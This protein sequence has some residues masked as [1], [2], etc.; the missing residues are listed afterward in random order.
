MKYAFKDKSDAFKAD[1]ILV[2]HA[3]ADHSEGVQRLLDKFHPNQDP[4]P[5]KTKFEFSGPLLINSDSLVRLRQ[6]H[7]KKKEPFASGDTING[8]EV[9]FTFYYP[10]AKGQ[11]Y[12]Y[13]PTVL[14]R[15]LRFLAT[16][17]AV[18][19]PDSSPQNLSSI[20]LNVADPSDNSKV[21]VSLNGDS[22][23]YS[24]LQAL[25][26][27]NPTVFKVPHHGSRYNS[28]P[29][30]TY[31]PDELKE[32]QQ[33][34]AA[35]ALLQ[36]RESPKPHN[37][38]IAHQV[39]DWNKS[40]FQQ[41][42]QSIT[43]ECATAAADGHPTKRQ[44]L[45]V[46]K[47]GL[48]Y[49]DILTELALQFKT[50]LASKG[51][52]V[53]NLLK[54][55]QK[56]MEKIEAN[57]KDPSVCP[58]QVYT[59]GMDNSSL[60]L[61]DNFDYED[62][63]KAVLLNQKAQDDAIWD[64]KIQELGFT[65]PTVNLPYKVSM[66][67]KKLFTYLET[68]RVF[69]DNVSLHL[70][71]NFYIQ[72]K[73]KTFFISSGE[74]FQHPHWQV[75]SGIIQA[76][77]HT[78]KSLP[79]YRCRVLLT[80]G[81]GI[82]ENKL[83]DN[84]IDDW[85]KYVSLQYFG[86]ETA[87]VTIDPD[88]GPMQ[89]L[90]G[91]VEW[92]KD[93]MNK[94]DLLEKYNSTA[95]AMKLKRLRSV[96]EGR[97]YAVKPNKNYWLDFT[98]D[99][100]KKATVFQLS[101]DATFLKLRNTGFS[102]AKIENK[103]EIMFTL[104]LINKLDQVAI[105]SG[106]IGS[107]VPSSGVVSYKLFFTTI[108]NGK[109]TW[110]YLVANGGSVTTSTTF[111]DGSY[112]LFE[113][114][115]A[116]TLR[117]ARSLA[118]SP[119]VFLAQATQAFSLSN[120]LS[121][122]GSTQRELTCNAMLQSLLR[123]PDCADVPQTLLASFFQQV[124]TW[125]VGDSSTFTSISARLVLELPT[126]PVTL[127]SFT[128]ISI[129]LHVVMSQRNVDAVIQVSDDTGVPSKLK[130][131]G[132]C[133]KKDRSGGNLTLARAKTSTQS[134]ASTAPA[135]LMSAD[136]HSQLSL[137]DYLKWIHYSG[138][139]SV[140]SSQTMLNLV[141]SEQVT[142]QLLTSGK[143]SE[144][145]DLYKFI[146]AM[147]SWDVESSSTFEVADNVTL[148]AN[149]SLVLPSKPQK[150]KEF[151]V[152]ST[153]LLIT[154]PK[155]TS[156]TTE[157]QLNATDSDGIPVT[158]T[159]QI[160]MFI[161]QFVQTFQEYLKVLGVKKDPSS[162]NLFDAVMFLLD[163]E[164]AGFL[165]MGSFTRALVTTVL[166]WKVNLEQTT[167]K[168]TSTPVG[169]KLLEATLTALVPDK[170]NTIDLGIGKVFQLTKLAFNV[171][172][173]MESKYIM[174]PYMTADVTVGGKSATITAITPQSGVLPFLKL[175]LT[176]SNT[177]G[178]IV[179]FLNLESS[180]ANLQI[181]MLSE[182]LK[183]IQITAAGFTIQQKVTNSRQS[184]LSSVFFAT[185]F[186]N[187]SSYLPPA[188][189]GLKDI[190]THIVIYQPLLSLRKVALD[191]SFHFEISAEGSDGKP[192]NVDLAAILSAEPVLASTQAESSYNFSISLQ[193]STTYV[194][195][196]EGVSL[197]AMLNTFGLKD[198]MSSAESIPFLKSLLQN[199]VLRNLIVTFNTGS[200]SIQSF[201]LNL[202][203]PGWNL[204]P[205]KLDL[206]SFD[207]YLNYSEGD[208]ATSFKG[209]AVFGGEYSISIQ[210]ELPP[211]VNQLARFSFS[212]SNHDFTIQKFLSVF[213]L[214]SIS[215]VPVVGHVL[216]VAVTDANLSL[217]KNDSGVTATEGQVSLY[218]ESINISSIFRLSQVSATIGFVHVEESNYVFGFSVRGFINE[219]IYLNV[220]YDPNTYVLSGQALVASFQQA[221]LSDVVGTFLQ[222]N[223]LDK[224]S[225]YKHASTSL[226]V[227]ISVA[228]EQKSGDFTLQNLVVDL[229]NVFSIG[230]I[231]LE[232]LKFE[233]RIT[234]TGST[235]VEGRDNLFPAGSTIMLTGVLTSKDKNFGAIVEFN[236]NKDTT[237]S[238]T[239]MAAIR[240]A[241]KNT[242]TL[243]S[244]LSLFDVT[245]PLV[246][247]IEGHEVPDFF[248]LA[249][250]EGLLVLSLPDF[251][252]TSFQVKVET[253]NAVD[254]L[255]S[256]KIT[257][258]NLSFEVK[259]SKSAT[260]T[261]TGTLLGVITLLGIQ[262]AMEG[263]K[264]K[265]GTVFKA[266]VG[267]QTADL[268]EFMKMLTPSDTTTPTIPSNV[269]LPQ[270]IPVGIAELVIGL[271]TNKRCVTFKGTSDL[272]WGID[273]G[274]TDFHIQQLGGRVTGVIS[275]EFHA[276]VIGL[277]QFSSSIQMNS[278]LHFGMKLDTV[279]AVLV[280][281]ASKVKVDSVADNL[282]GFSHPQAPS[283]S[284]SSS[285]SETSNGAV[286]FDSLLPNST[287]S[288]I[289]FS[290][291][292]INL[293]LTQSV[294][295][296]V[297]QIA[298]L[299]TGFLLA[300]KF[301]RDQTRYGYAFGI[302]LPRGFKFSQL[303]KAL[304]P[305]DDI[306]QVR[307]ATCVVMSMDVAKVSD[308]VDRMNAARKSAILP[309]DATGLVFPFTDL[310]IDETTNNLAISNGM[311]VYA[312]FDI[313]AASSD[314]IFHSIV[315]ISS[316]PEIPVVTLSATITKDPTQS[317]FRAHLTQLTLLGKLEFKDT[318]LIYHP[319]S[320]VT[321]ELHGTI[322]VHLGT[323][324]YSFNGMFQSSQ[325]EA[326]FSVTSDPSNQ[327]TILEPLGMFGISLEDARLSLRYNYPKDK[328]HTS[329]MEITASL[330]FYSSNSL[331]PSAE[332]GEKP[333]PI[334]TL[335]GLVIF[336]DYVP[337]VVSVTITPTRPLTIADFIAT[338]F[339]WNYN[340]QYL[341]IGIVNGQIYFAKLPQG[342][343]SITIDGFTY[344]NGYHISADTEVFS[345]EFTIEANIPLDRSGVNITGY[346]KRCIDLG[347]AEFTGKNPSKPGPE[348][349]FATSS[350]S[351]SISIGIG[352]VLF[353]VPLATADI[354]Y[355]LTKKVFTG[356]LT[357]N[358]TI[359]IIK[360]PSISFE[361]SKETGLR[362]TSFPMS[363]AFDF[364]L[365]DKLKNHEDS[366]GNLVDLAFK[367]GIQTKF[368]INTR[369]SKTTEPEVFLADIQ[370]TG[371]YDVLLAGQAKIAS[372][373]LP[374]L[375]VGIPREDDF[376]LH[377]LP[378]FILDLFTENTDRIVKQI[379]ENPQRLA[380]ILGFAVLK[381]VTKK[382]IQTLVCRKVD[383]EDFNPEDGGNDPTDDDFN[384]ADE[385]ENEF[386]DFVKSAESLLEDGLLAGAAAAAAGAEGAGASALGI[387][388][389]IISAIGAILSFFGII[390]SYSKK[391]KKAKE[392]EERI[393]N[394]QKQ[395]RDKIQA[396]L[397]IKEQPQVTFT[398]PDKL[399][400]S[401]NPL[402]D[403][404]A[405]YHLKVTGNFL[406]PPGGQTS[407]PIAVYD[408]T[409]SETL[410]LIKN[411]LFYNVV[412]I[413]VTVN[414]TLT[415][416]EGGYTSTFNG[417][418]YTVEVANVHPTLHAPAQVTAIYT[419]KTLEIMTAASSVENAKA[420]HFE[421]VEGTNKP[422]VLI[423]Q[424]TYTPSQESTT[425]QCVF[426]H[427][428]IPQTSKGPF[429]VRC[430]VVGENGSGIAASAFTYS[431]ALSLVS[432]PKELILTLS[433]FEEPKQ[434]I[435]LNWKLPAST[436]SITGF[437][438]RVV[439]KES[440]TILGSY[441]AK[442]PTSEKDQPPP[443]FPTSYSFAIESVVQGLIDHQLIPT[444]PAA[445]VMEAQVNAVGDSNTTI[446]SVFTTTA[447]SSL[448]S[449]QQV[450]FEFSAIEN[451]LHITWQFTQETSTYGIEIANATPKVVY[452]KLV[453]VNKDSSK[454]TDTKVGCSVP[455][456]D[457]SAVDDPNMNYTVKL[458]AVT[459]GN[460]ELD[461]LVPSEAP[462]PIQILTAPIVISM[463]FNADTADVTAEFNSVPNAEGY[464]FQ[465]RHDTMVLA[466]IT[467]L[468]SPT[469]SK[470]PP[471][472]HGTLN[473]NSFIDRLEGGDQVSG[474]VQAL[475][476]GDVL[477]SSTSSFVDVFTV[478]QPPLDMS[479]TYAP[480]KKTITLGC[481]RVDTVS[482]YLFGLLDPKGS[483]IISTKGIVIGFLVSG[484]LS[485][486]ALR[487]VEVEEWK[488]FALSVGDAT[489]L[490]SP[491][492]FF[493]ESTVHVLPKPMIQLLDF[494]STYNILSVT[495]PTI[496]FAVNYSLEVT[497]LK[498][499]HPLKSFTLQIPAP[500]IGQ[501]A[502]ATVDM[503]KEIP[504]WGSVLTALTSL[505]VSATA[506]GF[507]YYITSSVSDV[508]S[509][510]R[511]DPPQK[512]KYGYIPDNDHITLTCVAVKDIPQYVLGLRDIK[513]PD[514]IVSKSA[515]EHEGTVSVSLSGSDIRDKSDEWKVF[516]QSAG[517]STH[518]PSTEITLE[519]H[520]TVLSHPA[521]E[522]FTYGASNQMLKL[523]WSAIQG[524]STYTIKVT[525][526]NFDGKDSSF[527]ASSPPSHT[528]LTLDMNQKVQN[529]STVFT[530]V[531]S[532]VATIT[533][534]GSGYYITSSTQSSPSAQRLTTPGK[535]TI[536]SDN[537][538]V[539]IMWSTVSSSIGY[540]VVLKVNGKQSLS[541]HVN[542]TELVVPKSELIRDA[543]YAPMYKVAAEVTADSDGSHLPSFAGV[544]EA[545]LHVETIQTSIQFGGKGG[546]AFKDPIETHIPAIIGIKALRIRHGDQV[547]SIQVT[548]LLA[549][550]STYVSPKHGGNGGQETYIEF[551]VGEEI[552]KVLGKTNSVLVDQLTFIA[553][554]A[555]G[556]QRRYGP[557]GKTGQS[558]ITVT[559]KIL[560]LFGRSGTLLD[561]VGFYF[562]PIP[563]KPLTSSIHGSHDGAYFNDPI[564][565][566]SSEV[567]GIKALRI[568]H[569]SQVDS[570]QAIYL[571]D[572]GN[573][574]VAPKHGGDG[575]S[576][577]Y[578][579]FDAGEEI[580]RVDGKTNWIVIDQLTFT[581]EKA[582]GSI[583]KYGSF[584]VMDSSPFS[585]SGHIIGFLGRSGSLLHAIGF[586]YTQFSPKITTT[587]YFG[588]NGG[589]AFS[590]GISTHLP[591]ITGIE[592]I[593]IRHGDQVDSIQATY[594]V[595]NGSTWVAP[596]H[597]G[598]GGSET[599]IQ[600]TDDERVIRI[601]GKTNHVLVD[602]LTFLTQKGDGS[603]QKYG[604]F[605]ITG[606]TPFAVGGKILGFFGRSGNLLDAIGFFYIP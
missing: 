597:G 393:K 600:F 346:A 363:G 507:H 42:F 516:A 433:H 376:T 172:N 319:K 14:L 382:I 207:L 498:G 285:S 350:T 495:W 103:P 192:Q 528:S 544:A 439:H 355:N 22:V 251:S 486:D 589:H 462:N 603:Q 519:C 248:D 490:S 222:S 108:S 260:P 416:S 263:S 146:K 284:G 380:A 241:E 215:N 430:H 239:V 50:Y 436:E 492:T 395:L 541:K 117:T 313:A 127:H 305:I 362:V 423:A 536:T 26:G 461:S 45:D 572:S 163:S 218:Q 480:E 596:K 583:K 111:T 301:S 478:S 501:D 302:S 81:N 266:V 291:A 156:L 209:N 513:S 426:D 377:K 483:A 427:S 522:S 554:T 225:I 237:G 466:K 388:G 521:V 1:G 167:V 269:G 196:T 158:L 89:V 584:G 343:D 80:S 326:V 255:K 278:E 44:K 56:R 68:D 273:L 349:T 33:L 170:G 275:S 402:P 116:T 293:N 509:I 308:V 246:P 342:E 100:G 581:T 533:A 602:Q 352:L 576:E 445:V 505:S 120:Y 525:Y 502:K 6:I 558:P 143:L 186:T 238:S 537:T 201:L 561:A 449:P 58:T 37:L 351:T 282:L 262:V 323:A 243:L 605:G 315:Q 472:I 71:T 549:D 415:A 396:A 593:R 290:S 406:P 497:A 261:T 233:Y 508:S 171:P 391:K 10:G 62:A 11:L 594:R 36:L 32:T 575:R 214:G 5:G 274:F 515:D 60:K 364:D 453:M 400:V 295:L 542:E 389:G 199:V 287:T 446:D 96:A 535:L 15:G 408:S 322:T 543:G 450:A 254:L 184:W 250:K 87:S 79:S 314:S 190:H 123:Q 457:L 13:D 227:A 148:S 122:V 556:T 484:T 70:T 130:L 176:D 220:A 500:P 327:V 412:G 159:Y 386:N 413:F 77:Q 297:G 397:D 414:G 162:Y 280:S 161:E 344:S 55:L 378:K 459:A 264:E 8:F 465:L 361:W 20:L 604:P 591:D 51:I 331:P 168:Y 504:E 149:F 595:A 113:Q 92:K 568:C 545:D 339:K 348:L 16:A 147:F 40:S 304:S 312:E 367:E 31:V 476:G 417:K 97:Q 579:E 320:L 410:Q 586:Y 195:P 126:S 437:L 177:L 105:L 419:H 59:N 566:L 565:S 357:Y 407:A 247:T 185:Q 152:S 86:G 27:K 317:E 224:N 259:Y 73:A 443:P 390:G 530:K 569:G 601:E 574:W 200:K 421:L 46:I 455:Y 316:S 481:S 39:T 332:R 394:K 551:E 550:G 356:K 90:D 229:R 240:P 429:K 444:T 203:I 358:G 183:D 244:L 174:P 84:S 154:N 19:T 101:S 398:P 585:V 418:S 271:L 188:F 286:A 175:E 401:W 518:F 318:T 324:S 405:K 289:N 107:H 425:I 223:A 441:E 135:L 131:T 267:P 169:P 424:C 469:H 125:K 9:L 150:F 12:Y 294:F 88:L 82:D 580:I 78:H 590:D 557:F 245:P 563:V 139:P 155:T 606:K 546:I 38:L 104:Y 133:W 165:S 474:T 539:T 138:D 52:D 64:A 354:G 524:T 534:V 232:Q 217:L 333:M 114:P 153:S 99:P 555:N 420:Y 588:G 448:K 573:T 128:I 365:L 151:S 299:G 392:Q 257:L 371:T 460:E 599:F 512:L 432:P 479:Y 517:D 560:G 456:S 467:I 384:E 409:I 204:I 360:N 3:H 270:P 353:K 503:K 493:L 283:G 451:S 124:L 307:M 160:D 213:G 458:T 470:V 7:F 178:E 187:V 464:L 210:F 30:Q 24:V 329:D 144:Q 83:P 435:E 559:G 434:D 166:E 578:L 67:F 4:S 311:S 279:L 66:A 374:D 531:A 208:W 48:V 428:S 298:S 221:D 85:T 359:G 49:D 379:A 277:F 182:A 69:Q 29:L 577:T 422:Y 366:C 115:Q 296:L 23:G 242:L 179:S 345:V 552:V 63:K 95:G 571:L 526:R 540:T 189:S 236:L 91:A 137:A 194:G 173:I 385:T 592:A 375:S 145:S 562:I 499:D 202:Y 281:D 328:E 18:Y 475:G 454:P 334:L 387:L 383:A 74:K 57:L 473:I 72:I 164:T 47:Q 511:F 373:P 485:T 235:P 527:E 463:Q 288:I 134:D 468:N 548:Q 370:I 75:V 35:Q 109:E 191:V 442:R 532:I 43:N 321:L 582:D 494:D 306:L 538:N 381:T 292:Y 193:S 211:G 399:S 265:D 338:V 309:K 258:K 41:E 216:S 205:N 438:C 529:W 253:T 547:D 28:I 310:Q 477:S 157:L 372:I 93:S 587:E 110:H 61:P 341:N 488:A 520:V 136:D 226:T 471:P 228:L 234:D 112:F 403:K 132:L 249:L 404:G 452:S 330:N 118:A 121:Q 198:A 276:Y 553:K 231:S 570:I 256:P 252:M 197:S 98:E 34:L 219:K 337:V 506:I 567:V 53:T 65:P 489:H 440:N 212:N 142:S 21:L 369:L 17:A 25:A 487:K 347:F 180:I 300:G 510:E 431:T 496:A 230:S 141:V 140:L 119:K 76:A 268:Q 181:P 598:H 411:Q 325:T 447:M 335:S 54:I 482:E 102:K 303:L 368:N 491:H 94:N 523:A 272:Q 564:S 340:M 2:T 129:T 106:V 514:V 206:T 336:Q